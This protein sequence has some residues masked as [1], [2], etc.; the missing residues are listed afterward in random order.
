MQSLRQVYDGTYNGADVAIKKLRVNLFG[1]EE[2]ADNYLEELEKEVQLMSELE[3]P[4]ILR[5]IGVCLWPSVSAFVVVFS[6]C[7]CAYVC[8]IVL[9]FDGAGAR[10][11]L[12][13]LLAGRRRVSMERPLVCAVAGFFCTGR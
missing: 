4:C 11:R 3:H 5:F 8:A 1:G 6:D 13:W 7:C 2:G 10:R 9:H 12:G